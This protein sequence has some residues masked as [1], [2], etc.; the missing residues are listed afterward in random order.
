MHNNM[1]EL[2]EGIIQP[3]QVNEVSVISEL[4]S[5]MAN[6]S[7]LISKVVEG[8]KVQSVAVCGMCSMQGHPTD[9]CLQLMENGGWESANVVGY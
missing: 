7:T 9:Q 4:Q 8:S 6:L 5:Q 3:S 1:K 2:E